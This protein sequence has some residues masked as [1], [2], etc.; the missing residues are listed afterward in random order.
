MDL[1]RV[2]ERTSGL[3]ESIVVTA[4]LR[5][6]LNALLPLPQLEGR[7]HTVQKP[8]PNKAL[9]VKGTHG[10]VQRG[11]L[12]LNHLGS[13]QKSS[14]E[15]FSHSLQHYQHQRLLQ[16]S[17]C[18]V[19]MRGAFAKVTV[20]THGIGRRWQALRAIKL[21]ALKFDYG[22][23]SYMRYAAT[24]RDLSVAWPYS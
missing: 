20:R 21:E 22:N 23:C 16:R 13:R 4:R 1:C 14:L 18:H 6:Q 9:L 19:G 11:T 12:R 15:R 8:E 24:I 17:A 3:G 10:N 7:F 5:R 2:A